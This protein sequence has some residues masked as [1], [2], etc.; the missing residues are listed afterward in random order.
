MKLSIRI[1]AI[2]IALF[3]VLL[4]QTI[5]TGGDSQRLAAVARTRGTGSIR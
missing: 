2:V 3:S 5:G 1:G 4:L